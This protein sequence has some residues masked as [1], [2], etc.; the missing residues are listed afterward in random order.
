MSTVTHAQM[1]P[2]GVIYIQQQ[3]TEEN[4]SLIE[5]VLWGVNGVANIIAAIGTVGGVA[6]LDTMAFG[7][8]TAANSVDALSPE[9]LMLG[10]VGLGA[11]NLLGYNIARAE[12]SVAGKAF[13]HM[14][15]TLF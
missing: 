13:T 3:K 2:Q 6:V 15:K 8:A 11:L 1:P 12:C 10:T 7:A 5:G 14:S 9:T 4:K